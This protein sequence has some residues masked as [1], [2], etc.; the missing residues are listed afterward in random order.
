MQKT[1]DFLQLQSP[2]GLCSILAQCRIRRMATASSYYLSVVINRSMIGQSSIFSGRILDS[3]RYN[4][5]KAES[6]ERE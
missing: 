1:K 3:A 2:K 5:Y 4:A 6:L